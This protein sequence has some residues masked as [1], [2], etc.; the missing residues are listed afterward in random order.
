MRTYDID[1]AG[2]VSNIVYIRWLEDMR[3]TLLER[4]LPLQ[5]LH[6][7]GTTPV[8]LSTDI[9]YRR[10]IRLFQRVQGRIWV[11]GVGKVRWSL[12]AEIEVEGQLAA[13]ANHELAFV[14]LD[15]FR[16]IPVPSEFKDLCAC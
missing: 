1:Y 9:A 12:A 14:H 8:L 5:T 16:P 4:Y 7:R 6:A 2:I 3:M 10:A 15:T 11:S 13:T